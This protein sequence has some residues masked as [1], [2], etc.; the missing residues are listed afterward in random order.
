MHPPYQAYPSYPYQYDPYR[1]PQQP[2]PP[3]P[4]HYPIPP[5]S[6]YPPHSHPQ[7]YGP[8]RGAKRGPP[9]REWDRDKDDLPWRHDFHPWSQ[10]E[11]HRPKRRWSGE[12]RAEERERP[13]ILAKPDERKDSRKTSETRDEPFS[14]ES[15]KGKER[16]SAIKRTDSASSDTQEGSGKPRVT[17]AS[18]AREKS[19]SPLLEDQPSPTAKP[20]MRSAHP[21]KIMLRKLGGAES[22]TEKQDQHGTAAKGS[23][24][25]R[26]K[27]LK[28]LQQGDPSDAADT[29]SPNT[30]DH[31]GKIKQTAW[32]VKGRGPI[33]SPQ[34][35]YEPEGKKSAAQFQKYRRERVS[36]APVGKGES[37]SRGASSPSTPPPDV[38]VPTKEDEGIQKGEDEKEATEGVQAT[39]PTPVEQE[40]SQA[41][42]NVVE[43]RK[44]APDRPERPR[45]QDSGRQ[46]HEKERNRQ[47]S[48]ELR[49]RGR[50]RR[51]EGREKGGPGRQETGSREEFQEPS[52]D[53]DKDS[54]GQDSRDE[55]PAH[56]KTSGGVDLGREKGGGFQTREFHRQG[57]GE[58]GRGE[59]PG[60]K[61]DAPQGAVQERREAD[62]RRDHPNEP[63]PT[64][65]K[66]QDQPDRSGRGERHPS[67]P[68][69]VRT[70]GRPRREERRPREKQFRSAGHERRE[71]PMELPTSSMNTASEQQSAAPKTVSS[72]AVK[73]ATSTQVSEKMER[74]ERHEP[75]PPKSA[76]EHTE[77]KPD[78][79]KPRDGRRDDNRRPERV[80]DRSRGGHPS[81]RGSAGD[82]ERERGGRNLPRDREKGEGER[83][84]GRSF[85]EDRERERGSKQSAERNKGE[86]EGRT[87]GKPPPKD[88]STEHPER[89][90]RSNEDRRPARDSR[91]PDQGEKSERRGGRQRERAPPGGR[92]MPPRGQE[93]ASERTHRTEHAVEEGKA[94]ETPK[95]TA[96]PVVGYSGLEDI[97]SGSDWEAD[98]ETIPIKEP[99]KDQEQ[100]TGPANEGKMGSVPQSVKPHQAERGQQCENGRDFR[101]G[102][103][104]GR[105]RSE[106]SRG[107]RR[108]RE[109]G[110]PGSQRRQGGSRDNSRN[111]EKQ[112]ASEGSGPSS[113]VSQDSVSKSR[114]R[115]SH[116]EKKSRDSTPQPSHKMPDFDKYDLNSHKVAIVDE[117]GNE[118]AETGR[119]S[120][121]V[122]GEFVEVTSK[123][124]QKEKL[125]KEKEEQRRLDEEKRK[126][127]EERLRRAK[128]L[129]SNKPATNHDKNLPAT[130]RP[131]NAWGSNSSK[132]ETEMGSVWPV[133][134]W[135]LLPTSAAPGAQLKSPGL[136]DSRWPHGTAAISIGVIGDNL[137]LKQS[138][139]SGSAVNPFSTSADNHTYSLFGSV[140]PIA[141]PFLGSPAI[142]SVTGGS[143]LE[144]AVESTVPKL[145]QE[146]LAGV[147]SEDPIDLET[148]LQLSDEDPIGDETREKGKE[149]PEF[150]KVER[151]RRGGKN[152]PPRFQSSKG[153]SSGPGR[154]KGSGGKGGDEASD[155]FY[156]HPKGRGDKGQR[157]G[158]ERRYPQGSKS[159]PRTQSQPSGAGAAKGSEK[160]IILIT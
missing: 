99:G 146:A 135:M 140:N 31:E 21:K 111:S 104:R 147:S 138:I 122:Q 133:S 107:E 84:R 75:V 93:R 153:Q 123:K 44:A 68:E 43:Q 82:R 17:F 55:R 73:S 14:S 101:R 160:V 88:R 155:R 149:S 118:G 38:K 62:R 42:E 157:A 24:K 136:G 125:K 94:G 53:R 11:E 129:A 25:E 148:V 143:M 54:R 56:G 86:R 20:T 2:Y 23:K 32:S 13:R 6:G 152:L 36:G 119:L 26:P 45:R 130:H 35:L 83:E 57:R 41:P 114:D 18:D 87:F 131:I 63:R 115:A 150:Q 39:S 22:P 40:S 158:G 47:D 156:T 58:R 15:E 79:Q 49:D 27:D 120:P 124:A 102:A 72:E 127:E 92:R 154:G 33:T 110:R 52:K 12:E 142:P 77:Q 113:V 108:G 90:G 65:H 85:G 76:P 137:Q 9:D 103:G 51:E 78:H 91:R 10:H 132:N 145:S 16:S 95:V 106:E 151:N 128:K 116:S 98:V 97:E 109:S 105:G 1:Y 134:D 46:L 4:G 19:Q 121:S 64:V 48:R 7:R 59:H 50:H 139:P 141:S 74:V 80:S 144:A 100:R 66:D 159:T 117:I 34:T 5:Q 71:N 30:P 37:G 61:Q 89:G 126:L 8:Q 81:Q 67:R 112:G 28:N 96:K 70:E 3:H 60:R 69:P 29:D